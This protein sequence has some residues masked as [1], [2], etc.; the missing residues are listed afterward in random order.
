MKTNDPVE[1]LKAA[2]KNDGLFISRVPKK[3]KEWFKTWA[4]EE[5]EMD[6][7]MAFKWMVDYIKGYLSTSESQLLQLI[8]DLNNRISALEGRG[9]AEKRKIRLGNGGSIEVNRE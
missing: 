2:A 6:Y 8:D 9:Q 3:E 5:F 1:V 7:G 4:K